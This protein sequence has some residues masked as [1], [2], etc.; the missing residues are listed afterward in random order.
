MV[1]WGYNSVQDGQRDFTHRHS[2]SC[3][4]SGL[5][6]GTFGL[7]QNVGDPNGQ[8][9]VAQNVG[10]LGS[11]DG[12]GARAIVRG[13]RLERRLVHANLTSSGFHGGRDPC[14]GVTTLL[15]QNFDYR[16]GVVTPL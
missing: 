13:N 6:L 1:V 9:M 10:N 14:K 2:S 8:N 15:R 16:N 12:L 11:R 7:I 5:K 4:A 3:E